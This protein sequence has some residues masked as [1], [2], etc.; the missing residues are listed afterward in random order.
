[1]AKK[2]IVN[3]LKI[4]LHRLKE[5]ESSKTYGCG[6]LNDYTNDLARYLN[7]LKNS[8]IT[9]PPILDPYKHS[10]VG[11]GPSVTE[12]R[13][14]NELINKYSEILTT[15]NP[16]HTQSLLSEV[17][18]TSGLFKFINIAI[19]I[20]CSTLFYN[21]G[22]DTN[23]G[24]KESLQNHNIQLK[25]T[26]ENQNN[27]IQSNKITIDRLSKTNELN[28]KLIENQE[29]SIDSLKNLIQKK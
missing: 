14:L 2:E 11:G 6:I 9:L 3:N 13:V 17:K 4:K 8:T 20:S 1:M 7:E 19:I 15:L 5:L 29:S 28:T 21:V 18:E 22:K 12:T 16:N 25:D 26:I 27:I 23:N 10:A 24:I